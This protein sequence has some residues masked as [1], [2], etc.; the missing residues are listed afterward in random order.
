MPS[1][2]PLLALTIPAPWPWAILHGGKRIENRAW[3]PPEHLRGGWIALHSGKTWDTEGAMF[4]DRLV[5]DRPI[6]HEHVRSAIVGVARI[7][8]WVE[9]AEALPVE[10]RAWFTG[11]MA[12]RLGEVVEL[13]EPI[14][15]VRGQRKL[16]RVPPEVADQVRDGFRA[17]RTAS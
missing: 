8:G 12:W 15:D 10:Q 7:D 5:P 4:I 13:P 16:W 2:P 11:P 1:S 6:G 17:A 9:N 14:R 3:L